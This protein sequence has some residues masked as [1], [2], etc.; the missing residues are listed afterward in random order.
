MAKN[1]QRTVGL[2]ESTPIA[3][4]SRRPEQWIIYNEE[5]KRLSNAMAELPYEQREAV[6]LHIQGQ[7]KFREI[8]KLQ[9]VSVKTAVSRYRYGLNKLRSILDDEVM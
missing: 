3:S 2:D 4:R 7:M 6:V 1:R 5:F 8:A 9:D